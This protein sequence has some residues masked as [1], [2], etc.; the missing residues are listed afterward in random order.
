[1]YSYPIG[2]KVM[3]QLE[4]MNEVYEKIKLKVEEDY[5]YDYEARELLNSPFT[6]KVVD[7][8]ELVFPFQ[9]SSEEGIYYF[10]DVDAFKEYVMERLH[11]EEVIVSDDYY[12]SSEEWEYSSC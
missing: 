5:S 10:G 2:E 6:Q 9:Y 11:D 3:N 7:E 1:M 8:V 4:K 12:E